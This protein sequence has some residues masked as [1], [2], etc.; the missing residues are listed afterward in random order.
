M[1][2]VKDAKVTTMK[3]DQA[4]CKKT[5]VVKSKDGGRVQLSNEAA[6]AGWKCKSAHEHY[7][8]DHN[9]RKVKAKQKIAKSVKSKKQPVFK[10]REKI[11]CGTLPAGAQKATL[12]KVAKP[13]PE[14][15]EYNPFPSSGANAS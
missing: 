9:V 13:K 2:Y 12:K 8:P 6:D 5:I 3:C 15:A 4:G 1:S 14:A 10:P 11:G 7:C